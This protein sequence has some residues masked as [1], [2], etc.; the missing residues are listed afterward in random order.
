MRTE[1]SPRGQKLRF[2]VFLFAPVL[3]LYMV[4]FV[5]LDPQKPIITYTLAVAI[6]M[7]LWWVV[8][9]VPLAVTSLLPFVLFPIMGV[10]NGKAV[11]SN[12]LATFIFDI[13]LD[14]NLE[15]AK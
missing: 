6:L 2:A 9:I 8:E 3:F 14:A 7:A 11:A 5:D 13:T 1:V 4:F 12:Y 10:M 15:W